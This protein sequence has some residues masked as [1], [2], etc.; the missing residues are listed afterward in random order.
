M[1]NIGYSK[2]TSRR[3]L[4]KVIVL[5]DSGVGKTSLMN[6][7]VYKKFSYQYKTTIGAD[8][9]TRELQIGDKLVTLQIWDTAGQERFQS[10]G[11]A[12]YRGAD[13]CV[14]VYDVN[15]LKSF[16]SLN[17]WHLEFLKQADPANPHTF[18]FILL[19]NKVDVD[20]GHSRAVTEKRAREW[21]N[22][23]GSIPYLES[24]AKEDI[25][26]DEAFLWVAQAALESDPQPD[27]SPRSA[28]WVHPPFPSLNTR[29][30]LSIRLDAAPASEGIKRAI[31]LTDNALKHLHKM[32]LDYREYLCLRISIKQGGSS[33]MS[34]T[35]EFK[36]R[37]NTRP[38]DSVIDDNRFIIELLFFLGHLLKWSKEQEEKL[39]TFALD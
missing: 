1:D 20:G 31:S 37:S 18:P 34:Y 7:Y 6:Q 36:D 19:G 27:I 12:F 11:A 17:N 24:S 13:C 10:L 26:V 35:M 38:N 29:K 4:L 14:L 39:C 28:V 30:P 16:E 8:F 9:V 33:G 25:N 3:T 32:I 15:V 5:G 2:G 21:C 22:L 23:K